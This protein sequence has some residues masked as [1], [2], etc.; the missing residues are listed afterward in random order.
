MMAEKTSVSIEEVTDLAFAIAKKCLRKEPEA[1]LSVEQLEGEWRITV[2]ALER[3]SI[4][5]SL[6]L[7]A[8]YEIRLNKNGA[9]IGWTQKVI[10]RRCDRISPSENETETS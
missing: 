3:K 9:L 10:R 5:D 2:E 6:D 1:I 4:P 7:L 8:R